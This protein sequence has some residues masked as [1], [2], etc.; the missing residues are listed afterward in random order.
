MSWKDKLLPASFRGVPF[1]TQDDEA[2]FGRR[3]Q[4]HEYPNRDKPYSEDLGRVTRRDTISAYL[5]GDDYQAQR[6][7]LITAI[8]QAG[9]GKLIHPQYGELNVCI[10]GEIRVSH[11]ASDGRMCTISFNF[12]EAGELSFPTS[13]VATGQKL[14]SSCDAMTDCVTDAFGKDFGLDGM[15]D[16]IQNGVIS[17]ASDMMNTAIKTFDGVNSAISDAGR[18]LDGDLSVLLMPPSSGMNFV[19]RLQ[20]MWRSGNSLLGNSD[21]IINKIKGLSGFTVGRDLA[22]HGVWKTDS[23][24][25][26]TQTAQR[27]VVAQAIRTTALT[28]AAQSVSDLPQTRPPL[29]ATV[30]PQ[31][32]LPLVTHP[33]VTSLSD[34]VAVIPPVT[35]ESLTEIRDTLNTAIDQELLRVTDDALFLAINIVR[36]DV[37]RDIS[38]RLEQIEK[39][40]FRTPDEVLPALV[41]AADWYD[42]AARE[43]DIIGRNQITHP[44]FVP[45]KTLRV[46][47]R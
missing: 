36:A 6:A 22:P 43:T 16:F 44:G 35:Y 19:N 7:Q 1:K 26:Q 40:T 8:N 32:Q 41:L 46:P 42:S 14:V 13:G 23:K 2:T 24:T 33:A 20:R 29:T 18:L 37:N 30:T 11:S 10:D 27:N 47:I 45:V 39:T 12:V 4:T 17:D 15:A 25:I 38:M 21:D 34:A 3:T 31:A 28:E 9:P 5:I